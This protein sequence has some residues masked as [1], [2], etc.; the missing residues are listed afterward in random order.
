MAKGN[1]NFV[2]IEN[3][4]H[5]RIKPAYDVHLKSDGSKVATI[6]SFPKSSSWRFTLMNYRQNHSKMFGT[7]ASCL[8][9]IEKEVL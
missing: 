3:K 5:S 2:L 1:E 7:L 9:A 8:D 6:A 4:Y